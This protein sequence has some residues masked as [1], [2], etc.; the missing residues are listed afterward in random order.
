MMPSPQMTDHWWLS[1]LLE[2]YA[3]GSGLPRLEVTGLTL[4]S[5]AAA[6]G[7]V[8]LASRGTQRHGLHYARQAAARGAVAIVAEADSEWT[9]A[10]AAT[11]ASDLQLPIIVVEDLG[12]RV[13]QLAARFFGHPG[14]RLRIVG[15]TG[16]NGKTTVSQFLAQALRGDW[17]CGVL[18]TIGYG[19]PGALQTASHTTPDA[20]RLQSLLSDLLHQGARAVAMEV[21]SHALVQAR[22]A[23]VPFHTAVFT[24]L[25]RD[26]LDYHGDM[27]SYAAAKTALFRTPGLSIAVVT[28]DDAAGRE[29]LQDL[30]EPVI[31][32]AV[33]KAAGELR[34][35]SHYVQVERITSDGQGL[36]FDVR[37]SWGSGSVRTALLGV[38]NI[39]N[40]ALTL[41]VLLAWGVR[42]ED[43]TARLHRLVAVPGRMEAFGGAPRP[44]VVVDYAHTPD[45]LHK[46]LR[47]LRS[48][49]R[50]KLVCVFGCGGDRDPGKRPEM[51]GVAERAA[52]RVIL[53]DDN[54]RTEDGN[55]IIAAIR[56][57]MSDPEQC[58]V[59]RRRAHAIRVAIDT[60]AAGDVVLIAGKGHEEYQQVGDKCLPF[61][62]ADHVRRALGLGHDG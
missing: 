12:A 37:S 44:L 28:T 51:G 17:H 54:P 13:S 22:V 53:T 3:D 38:F 30:T 6:P 48:H 52:D 56:A 9:A 10:R 45:A 24:N 46:A 14:A 8:F 50:G 55:A 61:S 60:A 34:G 21:S 58:V 15:V 35:P 41:A 7:D 19:F 39:E 23:A 31:R 33:G 57:G 32:V 26:H 25:S 43:A 59:E 29:L 1:D 2:G 27:V 16:T 49:T 18:G 40:L 36:S 20:V 47:A 11:V 42:I 5:R 4:D 62:D